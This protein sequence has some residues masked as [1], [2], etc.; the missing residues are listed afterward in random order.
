MKVYIHIRMKREDFKKYLEK[1]MF[2]ESFYPLRIFRR[3]SK[4]ALNEEQKKELVRYAPYTEYSS[5]QKEG[6][7][8]TPNLSLHPIDVFTNA[9]NSKKEI[10]RF[11]FP[12]VW[13]FE[14][15]SLA[16][17]LLITSSAIVWVQ[18]RLQS[19]RNTIF[20]LSWKGEGCKVLQTDSDLWTIDSSPRECKISNTSIFG[21][22]HLLLFPNTAATIQTVRSQTTRLHLELKTGRIYLWED[23]RPGNG[24]RF[25]I[26]GWKIQLTGTKI[27]AEIANT[28]AYF[29][30]LEGSL[31]SD[32][33]D[34]D[35]SVHEH[36]SVPGESMEIETEKPNLR[37]VILNRTQFE[38]LNETLRK[39]TISSLQDSTQASY[40]KPPANRS[41][42]ANPWIIRLK[43]G[44]ILKGRIKTENDR[45]HIFTGE[46]EEILEEREVLSISK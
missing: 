40:F 11:L 12:A 26:G 3:S 37:K 24:T 38:A 16:C 5:F 34:G 35:T 21:T 19:D 46:G 8:E 7:E 17:L 39:D 31:D 43:D 13:R 15:I 22:T 29:T 32:Y 20:E 44:R 33:E 36:L 1:R 28:K 4:P 45:I 9:R 30:L 42:R 41:L 14:L 2:L 10:K 25:F 27:L 23:L 18:W 6:S